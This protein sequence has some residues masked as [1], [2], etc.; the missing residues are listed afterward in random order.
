MLGQIEELMECT[1]D[2]M[3]GIIDIS[4]VV[5]EPIRNGAATI[6]PISKVGL[7][8]VT[9]GGEYSETLPKLK[10]DSLPYAGGS[11]GGVSI[12]P[13]GFLI[14]E[15][16]KSQYVSVEQGGESE[17]WMDILRASLNILQH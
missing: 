17:P 6:V 14:I 12:K 9:G 13:L 11:G 15:N 8:F 3:R 4:S 2:R 7:G 16:G 10:D 5:G 1:L